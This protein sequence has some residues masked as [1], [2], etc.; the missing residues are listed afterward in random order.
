MDNLADKRKEYDMHDGMVMEDL[1]KDPVV[2]FERWY[3]DAEKANVDEPNAMTLATVDLDGKP[4]A[5]IVLLKGFD[6]NGFSFFSNY[7]SRKAKEILNNPMVALVFWWQEIHR[8]VRIE[9]VAHKMDYDSSLSYFHSRPRGS[10]LSA[11]AS[12]QS[13]IIDKEE[14]Y[15]KRDEVEDKFKG[16]DLIPLPDFWGGFIIKPI[17]IEF[18]QGRENRFH[19]RFKYHLADNQNWVIDR[20]AP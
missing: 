10:Q 14:L 8:Q 19:D 20:L 4:S 15:K 7:E 9:G 2:Q 17:C 12:S 16:E 6:S 18:W 11:W 3:Q 13:N 5:R 1:A